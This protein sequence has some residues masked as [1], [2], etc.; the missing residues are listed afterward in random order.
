MPEIRNPSLVL[1]EFKAEN[2]SHY[3][4]IDNHQDKAIA[5]L[6]NLVLSDAGVAGLLDELSRRVSKL[7]A[8]S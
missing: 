1:R 6:L 2:D 4:H 7:E 3:S 8:K 5:T